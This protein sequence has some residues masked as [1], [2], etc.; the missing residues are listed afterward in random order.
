MTTQLKFAR[1]G[2]ELAIFAM[3]LG[4]ATTVVLMQ[5]FQSA[6]E[7]TTLWYEEDCLNFQE[8]ESPP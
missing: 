5:T 1:G 4:H 8:A 3:A 2:L 7:A 6:L